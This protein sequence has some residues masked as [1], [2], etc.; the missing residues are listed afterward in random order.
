MLMCLDMIPG[1][2]GRRTSAPPESGPTAA[3]PHLS[4]SDMARSA[5]A[6]SAVFRSNPARADFRSDWSGRTAT[7]TST[8]SECR[9]SS[10]IL[11]ISGMP[12]TLHSSLSVPCILDEAPAAGITAEMRGA[13]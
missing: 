6:T 2:S 10:A 1:M 4:D 9:A 5:S 13:G 8:A 11:R 3:I 7:I 12:P